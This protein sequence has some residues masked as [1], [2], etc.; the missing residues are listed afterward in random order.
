VTTTNLEKSVKNNN[1]IFMVAVILAFLLNI[2]Y[3]IW[4][5]NNLIIVK[6]V[7]IENVELVSE[8]E[9]CPGD[10]LIFKY[11]IV[12]RGAGQMVRD[13]T[14]W[15]VNPPRTLI[16]SNFRRFILPGRIEQH[17]HEAWP[18]PH[19]YFNYESAEWEAIPAGQYVKLMSISSLNYPEATDTVAVQFAIGEDCYVSDGSQVPD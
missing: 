11:E 8:A 1:R 7:D 17:L 18:I 5:D 13:L 2:G 3:Q 15:D 16:Y 9:L 10:K 12:S 4:K 6:S 14:L 19:R